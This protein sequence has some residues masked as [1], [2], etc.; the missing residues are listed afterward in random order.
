[1]CVPEQ[2]TKPCSH[3]SLVGSVHRRV[4][5][6]SA[7]FL[8]NGHSWLTFCA[9]LPTNPAGP[10]AQIQASPT[11]S[12]SYYEMDPCFSDCQLSD[13]GYP[14][15]STGKKSREQARIGAWVSPA[16]K[17]P[18]ISPPTPICRLRST[19]LQLYKRSEF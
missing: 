18:S 10:K 8:R 9:E 17:I 13:M 6:D 16:I 5:R 4:Q 19:E 2:G 14:R 1:M 12:P 3:V 7:F 11:Q 15:N